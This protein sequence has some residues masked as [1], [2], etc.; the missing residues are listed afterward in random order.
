MRIPGCEPMPN[1]LLADLVF[2]HRR[3]HL[4]VYEQAI[5]VQRLVACRVG[6]LELGCLATFGILHASEQR[7]FEQFR[8]VFELLHVPRLRSST[9]KHTPNHLAIAL[10]SNRCPR[11]LVAR[12]PNRDGVPQVLDDPR[13]SRG[14]FVPTR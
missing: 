13:T 3:D 9:T 12:Y 2:W 5:D 1:R 10:A 14:Y 11:N 6:R 7:R 4:V 8:L